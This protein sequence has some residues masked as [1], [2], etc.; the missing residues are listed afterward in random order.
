[1]NNES[2]RSLI[3]MLGV[4]AIG[5]IMVFG[6]VRMYQTVQTRQKRF[7]AEQDIGTLIDNSRTMFGGRRNFT[8]ISRDYLIKSGALK[9]NTI[10]GYDFR[11]I[12]SEDGTTFSVIFDDMTFGDCAYFATKK[13]NWASSVAVNNVT[14]SPASMCSETSLNKVEFVIK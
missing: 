3:E 14:I 6:S 1:M 2:G 11:I 13:Y 12:A 5:G 8:G 4:L 10:A 9:S 7:L